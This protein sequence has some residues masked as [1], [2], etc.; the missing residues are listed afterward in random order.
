MNKNK[1]LSAFFIAILTLVFVYCGDDKKSPNDP[2]PNMNYSVGGTISGLTGQLKLRINVD[3]EA[4]DIVTI[5]DN[6][7]F[8]FSEEVPDGS[9]YEIEPFGSL[10]DCPSFSITAPSGT[11]EGANVTNVVVECS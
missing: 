10:A 5:T 9:D 3:G 1:H 7:S 2:D 6:G 4:F 8:T 11:I